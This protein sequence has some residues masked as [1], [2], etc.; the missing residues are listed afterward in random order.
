M[1]VYLEVLELAEQSS[2]A[3]VTM[4]L[5]EHDRGVRGQ[6][7]RTPVRDFV[8]RHAGRAATHHAGRDTTRPVNPVAITPVP[9]FGE[10]TERERDVAELAVVGLS[11]AQIARDL[12]VAPTTVSYHL[13]NIYRKCGVRTRH[14]LTE[15]A[16]SMAPA[17]AVAW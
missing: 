13:S 14:E 11:Y 5:P 10:L 7:R 15:L 3:V 12:F 4:R 16:R 9:L 17:P 6:D 1:S 8:H 2:S